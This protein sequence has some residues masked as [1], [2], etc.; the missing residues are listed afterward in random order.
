MIQ[1]LEM[2]KQAKIAS[3]LLATLSTAEKN[4]ILLHAAEAL[5]KQEQAILEE[6]KKMWKKQ[7]K[8]ELRNL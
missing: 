2:G 8:E 7:G 3:Y 5:R 1:L 6:N 4:S